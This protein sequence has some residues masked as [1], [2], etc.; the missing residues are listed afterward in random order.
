MNVLLIV[1]CLLMPLHVVGLDIRY[2]LGSLLHDGEVILIFPSLEINQLV[3]SIDLEKLVPDFGTADI[4]YLIGLLP[5]LEEVAKEFLAE[6]RPDHKASSELVLGD[7]GLLPINIVL[8]CL[9]NGHI[10]IL[11][12]CDVKC[13]V[14]HGLPIL[15]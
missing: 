6:H 10:D 15:P 1:H 9:R 2:H 4:S 7:K 8:S 3:T 13:H 14:L 5:P 12:D 11:F